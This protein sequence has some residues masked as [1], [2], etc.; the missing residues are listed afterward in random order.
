MK[1]AVTGGAG[2]VGS[3]LAEFLLKK[4]HKII[5][6]T[7]TSVKNIFLNEKKEVIWSHFFSSLNLRKHIYES[8][9][10]DCPS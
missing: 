7:K 9:I 4:R 6:C 3:H 2:F 1:F 5:V 10:T 8:K